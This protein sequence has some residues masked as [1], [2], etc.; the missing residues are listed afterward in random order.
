MFMRLAITFTGSIILNSVGKGAERRL[1]PRI[2][3][4][5]GKDEGHKSKKPPI[6]VDRITVDA[7][8]G[9]A[10]KEGENHRDR[11]ASTLRVNSDATAATDKMVQGREEAIAAVLDAYAYRS[12]KTKK[13]PIDRETYERLLRAAL[14]L[15]DVRRSAA[16]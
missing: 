15:H 9:R 12:S 16:V 2:V 7:L 11:T 4:Y 13:M 5:A 6:S 10:V 8:P 1:Y 14:E 3:P